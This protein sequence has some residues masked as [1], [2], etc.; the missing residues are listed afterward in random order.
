[1]RPG[2]SALGF[3]EAPGG[4]WRNT[5]RPS[6][7]SAH[8]A[9]GLTGATIDSQSSPVTLLAGAAAADAAGDPKASRELRSEAESLALHSPTYYATPGAHLAPPYSTVPS[10]LVRM[11]PTVEVPVVALD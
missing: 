9:L 1:L 4:C 7:R 10:I 6:G 2:V 11:P 5:L 3:L 8:T